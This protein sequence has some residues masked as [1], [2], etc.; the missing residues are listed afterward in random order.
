[1]PHAFTAT[2]ASPGPEHG[3]GDVF[4]DESTTA[5]DGSTHR[6]ETT[7]GTSRARAREP[8]R[9]SRR[10][11]SR[12]RASGPGRRQ[13]GAGVAMTQPRVP[14]EV[15]AVSV[16]LDFADFYREAWPGA[17]RLAGL[18][19]QDARVAEDLAQD[20]FSRV[21]PK[22]SRVENPNAYL[23]AAIVNAC[24]SWQSRRHTE[25]TKLPLVADP[26]LD[27][28]RVRRA[29]RRGG[30]AAVPPTRRARPA[31]PPRA[32]R[33]R[34]RRRTRVPARN[35]EVTH[36]TRARRAPERNRTMNRTF[37]DDLESRCA[38]C[39]SGRP[40]RMRVDA[41]AWDDA[42]MVTVR[43][44][45]DAG[46]G[47]R[48]PR[49]SSVA[50]AAALVVGIAAIAPAGNGVY[51]AGQPGSPDCGAVRHAAG[52]PRGR[53][54]L[55][56]EANG[57]HV[58]R[59][60]EHGR[61]PQRSRDARQVHDARAHMERARR[62]D[63]R[64]HLLRVGR[65]PVVGERDAHLQRQVAGRLDRI[66]RHVLPHAARSARSPATSTCAPTTATGVCDSPN[67]QPAGV[68][69]A[70]RVHA[71]GATIAVRVQPAVQR[72][73]HAERLGRIRARRHRSA[74]RRVV[75]PTVADPHAFTY[76]WTIA[77]RGRRADRARPEQA[78][79]A[80][81]SSARSR[82]SR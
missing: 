73:R 44:R 55:Q 79:G 5:G 80:R 15:A 76:D 72:G 33:G 43:S 62:R 54:R 37:D 52:E 32:P 35:R 16:P 63:A 30:R 6:G 68:P 51:V 77:N 47:P 19:V 48:W 8:N 49:S 69:P 46:R 75:Q 41:P 9:Q 67:L 14:G 65:S 56:I 34:D 42:P 38:T 71:R 10:S 11:G 81:R 7:G 20:A 25:R 64:E 31:V 82:P 45:R 74:R 26:R 61:R 70:R 39:S 29:R 28:P 36:V 2:S 66:H 27:R 1:M 4:D 24:R 53:Q 3:F 23:R 40:T 22:W 18:L 21:F 60:R 59:G 13:A 12:S 78:R 58:H 57:Q 17:V 50:A